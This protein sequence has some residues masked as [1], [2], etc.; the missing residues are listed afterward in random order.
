MFGL[1][2]NSALEL[3]WLKEA[4]SARFANIEGEYICLETTIYTLNNFL[5]LFCPTKSDSNE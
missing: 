2:S 1:I 4:N 3:R 5:T